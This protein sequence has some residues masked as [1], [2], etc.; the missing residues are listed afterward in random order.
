M[1]STYCR[2]DRTEMVAACTLALDT[3]FDTRTYTVNGRQDPRASEDTRETSRE[4][5][6]KLVDLLSRVFDLAKIRRRSIVKNGDHRPSDTGL[7]VSDF[8]QQ[9]ICDRHEDVARFSRL[10]TRQGRRC[11]VSEPLYDGLAIFAVV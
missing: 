5:E 9:T 1:V 11:C 10:D 8:V 7:L 6:Q 2:V 3:P 4:T